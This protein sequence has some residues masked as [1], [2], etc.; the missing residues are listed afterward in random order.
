MF[1]NIGFTTK[2]KIESFF[3]YIEKKTLKLVFICMSVIFFNISIKGKINFFY[4]FPVYFLNSLVL[5]KF[6][7]DD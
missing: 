3:F 7:K 4:I 5:K 6:F 1:Y 2:K